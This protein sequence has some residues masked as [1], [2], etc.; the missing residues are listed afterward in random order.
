MPTSN[1]QKLLIILTAVVAGLFAGDKLVYTPLK[2]WWKSREAE[3][4]R[5]REEIAEG[6]E[7]IDRGD[8]VRTRWADMR[9]NMLPNNQSAQ[10]TL[11]N[12]LQEWAEES[13]ISVTALNPQ[14]M[15]DENYRTLDCRVDAEGSLWQVTRF[16]YN[17]EK[18]PMGLKLNSVD[19][20]SKDGTGRRLTLVLEI[21]GLVLAAQT[22]TQ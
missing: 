16:I 15:E 4:E 18:G 19:I 7:L 10:G 9:R 20:T 17:I 6:R 21:S 2:N 11:L 8:A 22:Q 13:G 1:R 14:W 3:I 5:L 12:A